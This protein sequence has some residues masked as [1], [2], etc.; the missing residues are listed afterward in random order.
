ML[1]RSRLLSRTALLGC[2]GLLS[3]GGPAD[4]QSSERGLA[5]GAGHLVV[6]STSPSEGLEVGIPRDSWY[7]KGIALDQQGRWE[8]SF[9]AYR[10]AR[11]EFERVLK[12]RPSWDQIIRGWQLKAEFQSDQSQR[13]KFPVYYRYGP[14]SSSVLF[15]RA[16]AKHNKWLGI[17]AFTGRLDRKLQ[18]EIVSEYQKALQ[19]T[20]SYDSARLALAA[21]LH[22]TGR[23]S[24]ARQEF[25]QVNYVGR[26]W[27]AVEVAYY[28]C[29]AGEA[30]RAMEMLEK[31]IQYNSG[32]KRHVLRSNDFDRLR[33]HPRFKSLVGTP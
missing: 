14:P 6:V 20:P 13:L 7:A 27:L 29:A 21:M 11:G 31:A 28:Y 1:T 5:T 24:E 25:A 30:E 32:N 33:P 3:L 18:E 4:A 2:W 12:E 15:Y 10:E 26:G 17:R 23:H 22:E 9:N 8:D 16:A 19:Q